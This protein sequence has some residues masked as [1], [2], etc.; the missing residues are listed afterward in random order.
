MTCGTGTIRVAFVVVNSPILIALP[1]TRRTRG[2][3]P[4]SP[5]YRPPARGHSAPCT[6]RSRSTGR[7]GGTP[8]SPVSVQ[9]P[10]IRDLL[11]P[12]H[13]DDLLARHPPALTRMLPEAR[14]PRRVLV[15]TRR[16]WNARAPDSPRREHHEHEP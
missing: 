9:E 15:E 10:V 1:T 4:A 14:C 3:P 7:D 8:S 2:P 13:L 6:P 16:A 12:L 11:A 5:A